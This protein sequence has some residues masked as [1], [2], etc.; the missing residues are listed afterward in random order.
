[1]LS[2]HCDL[3]W[4]YLT[5]Q[6]TFART[7][8]DGEGHMHQKREQTTYLADPGFAAVVL[9]IAYVNDNTGKAATATALTDLGLPRS[10]VQKNLKR[11]RDKAPEQPG[12][13]IRHK[14]MG[15]SDGFHLDSN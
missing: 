9:A 14:P 7:I 13:V 11:L 3:A 2:V 12:V 6:R 8:Y 15:R 4:Q 10:V 5:A 1:M